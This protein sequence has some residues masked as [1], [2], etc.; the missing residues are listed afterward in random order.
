M[1][2]ADA[3][4][5]SVLAL[6][7]SGQSRAGSWAKHSLSISS[8][9]AR[10]LAPFDAAVLHACHVKQQKTY[11]DLSADFFQ[12][13]RRNQTFCLFQIQNIHDPSF[14]PSGRALASGTEYCIF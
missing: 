9:S 7:A 13:A 5:T 3:R 2:G 12:V 1:T 4:R 14:K 11:K 6:G 10:P 8:P